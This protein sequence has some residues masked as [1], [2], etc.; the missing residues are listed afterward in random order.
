MH[1]FWIVL[2]LVD[3]MLH[4]KGTMN[5]N[6]LN[7]SMGWW[8]LA[9]VLFRAFDM[10]KPPPIGWLD[11]HIKGGLGIM[12]DDWVAALMALVCLGLVYWGVR[13]V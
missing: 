3:V 10:L 6:G 9:F 7:H 4:S 13:A 12:L 5:D 1:A 8:L 11:Q 2:W